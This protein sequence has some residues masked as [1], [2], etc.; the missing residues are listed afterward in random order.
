VSALRDELEALT[1]RVASLEP[2][3]LPDASAAELLLWACSLGHEHGPVVSLLTRLRR[4]LQ[5]LG[6]LLAT[7]GP[8]GGPLEFVSPVDLSDVLDGFARRLR[9]AQEFAVR[10]SGKNAEG[11]AE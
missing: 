2:R 9:V 3:D 6:D 10:L 7:G 1:A 5:V 11:S 4:E 8:H